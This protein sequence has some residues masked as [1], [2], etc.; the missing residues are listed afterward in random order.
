MNWI[1]STE[2]EFAVAVPI[3]QLVST[4]VLMKKNANP[5]DRPITPATVGDCSTVDF[6]E[7]ANIVGAVE[8][9]RDFAPFEDQDDSIVEFISANR[10]EGSDET[11]ASSALVEASIDAEEYD[12]HEIPKQT[13]YDKRTS[14]KP[15]ISA[16]IFT[17]TLIPPRMTKLLT[18]N[19]CA[20]WCWRRN[21]GVFDQ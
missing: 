2:P 20:M 14:I 19:N 11:V 15:A 6:A 3:S 1:R 8:V 17:T 16:G 5:V 18:P 13:I 4:L 21:N 7:G 12:E 10:A 9:E